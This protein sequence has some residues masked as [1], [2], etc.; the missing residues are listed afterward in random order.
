MKQSH[1]AENVK[2]ALLDCLP[3]SLLQNIKQLDP[4]ETKKIRKK[5]RP[6]LHV[7]LKKEKN[8]TRF[9]SFRGVRVV[10]QIKQNLSISLGIFRKK[11]VT[12]IVVHFSFTE[13]ADKKTMRERTKKISV[14]VLWLL[15]RK[16][17]K[18]SA[19]LVLE[20]S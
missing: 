14:C 5:S 10:E 6:V 19:L 2:V 9:S 4:L 18:V 20:K 13:C 17:I 7:T 8:E 16:K 11:L 15:S 12:A 1:S 3:S